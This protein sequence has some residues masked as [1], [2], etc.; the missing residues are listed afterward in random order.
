M[1]VAVESPTMPAPAMMDD[2]MSG[3]QNRLSRFLTLE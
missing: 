3:V 2:R 1:T